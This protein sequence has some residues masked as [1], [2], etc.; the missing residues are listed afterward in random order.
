[1]KKVI[2]GWIPKWM[3]IRPLNIIY[4]PRDVNHRD[5]VVL[6]TEPLDEVFRTKGRKKDWNDA[7]WP[8]K[9]I[10]ITIEIDE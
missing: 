3:A 2:K 4:W 7:S 9:Q 8:P 5:S 6:N 10:T 1:M